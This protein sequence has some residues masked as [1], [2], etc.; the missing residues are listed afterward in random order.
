MSPGRAVVLVLQHPSMF[1]K[2]HG[3]AEEL[4]TVR[5]GIAPGELNTACASAI[6]GTDVTSTTSVS[7]AI[8]NFFILT[9]LPYTKII[10]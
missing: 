9:S 1:P 10:D 8:I 6:L 4:A 7:N 2:L 5:V 3:F